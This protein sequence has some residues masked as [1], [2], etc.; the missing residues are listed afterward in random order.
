MKPKKADIIL[1]HGDYLVSRMIRDVTGSYWNHAGIYVGKGRIVEARM[2]GVCVSQFV[3]KGEKT[4][5]ISHDITALQRDKIVSYALSQVGKR[6]DYTQLLSLFFLWLFKRGKV[7]NSDNHFICSELVAIA[8]LDAGIRLVDKPVEP[9]T[10][11]DLD[12]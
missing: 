5:I 9:I 2:L 7:H 10:P 3:D 6:Y 12:V 4:R 1:S 11:G 8:Y